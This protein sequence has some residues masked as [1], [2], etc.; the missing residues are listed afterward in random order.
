MQNIAL[1]A[2]S[3]SLLMGYVPLRLRLML[4]SEQVHIFDEMRIRA[5]QSDPEEAV[6]CLEYVAR[7]YPS[8]T[9][10]EAGSRLDRMVESSRTSSAR[11]II[12][13]LRAKTGEDLGDTP[14]PWIEK[15]ATKK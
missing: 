10:Q 8:G 4:G 11:E 13:Y 2:I 7:Y 14:E 12:A 9:K 6:G 1:A 5:L 3:V 15:Y